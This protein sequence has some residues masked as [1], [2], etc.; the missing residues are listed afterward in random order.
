MF[1]GRTPLLGVALAAAVLFLGTAATSGGVRHAG[2][3]GALAVSN[4]R[5]HTQFVKTGDAP[6]TDDF[7]RAIFDGAP[8]HSP[9]DRHAYGVDL[10]ARRRRRR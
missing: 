2:R 6:P 9:Q 4:V 3:I 10:A 1:L 7:C 8:G 5:V